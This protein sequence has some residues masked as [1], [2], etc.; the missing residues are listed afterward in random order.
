MI[1]STSSVVE[2]RFRGKIAW[3]TQIDLEFVFVFF[4]CIGLFILLLF[5]YGFSL[6]GF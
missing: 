3:A 4:C 5:E 2:L 1:K 6:M